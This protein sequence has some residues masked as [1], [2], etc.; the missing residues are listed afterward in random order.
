MLASGIASWIVVTSI[1]QS[2]ACPAYSLADLILNLGRS[3][4]LDFGC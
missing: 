2:I 1:M 4:L 3:M